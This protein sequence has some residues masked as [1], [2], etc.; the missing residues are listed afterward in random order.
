M[1]D[2]QDRE[3]TQL[4]RLVFFRDEAGRA[5][6]QHLLSELGWVGATDG[7]EEEVRRNV[8]V[9]IL[10][11]L[12]VLKPG[13]YPALIEAFGQVETVKPEPRAPQKNTQADLVARLREKVG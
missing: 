13:C 6:L 2:E 5:V 4:Y 7:L 3:I 1:L 8:A 11:R 12:G 9:E 10:G